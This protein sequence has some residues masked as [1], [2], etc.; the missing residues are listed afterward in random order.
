MARI[1]VIE[2]NPTNLELM[3]YLLNAFGHEPLIAMDGERG[4]GTVQHESP[5][6]I[7]CDIHLPKMDGYEVA[8]RLKSH[9]ALRDIPLIAVTALAMMGDRD[10]ILKAGFDGYIPKPISPENFVSHVESYLQLHQRAT[11]RPPA[12]QSQ[13]RAGPLPS[14]NPTSKD[15][16]ILVL[17]DRYENLDLLRAILEPSGYKVVTA[18]AVRTAL[19]AARATRPD[20][21]LSDVYLQGETGHDLIK[22]VKAD[23]ELRSIPF[24]FISS[25]DWAAREGADALAEGAAAYITRPIEP[26]LLLAQIQKW[27][28]RT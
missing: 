23:P 18:S 15:A 20:L 10:K 4:L 12:E 9:P 13:D 19:A 2:D 17:D 22:V 21:I 16:T 25:A 11:L 7:I 24:L 8:R 3:V 1:L 26:Q 28:G 6:L 5:D 27:L 14:D